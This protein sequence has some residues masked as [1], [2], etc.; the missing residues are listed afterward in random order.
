MNLK[1]YFYIILLTSSGLFAQKAYFIDGYHGGIWGHYPEGYTSYVVNQLKEHPDWK[2]N[3]EIEPETWDRVE[4]MDADSYHKLQE[5]FKDQSAKGRVEYVNP[6]Y[7]QGYLFNISGESIISQF[8]YGIKK[9][10][11]HFPTA[12]FTSYSSEEPC[13]TSALPQILTSFG[14]TNASLKNP[15]T[16][17]GG[18]TRAHG[19]E[20]VN[21]I[22]PDGTGITTVPR[23]AIEILK[24]GSAWETIGNANSPE[25]I[26]AAF[27]YGIKNP[28]GMTLQDAGWKL[29]PW[30]KK[31]QYKPSEYTTWRNYFE[32]VADK[33]NITDWNFSQEDVLVSLVWGSQVLQKL[34]QEVRASENKIIQAEKIAFLDLLEN[35][36]AYPENR[37]QMAWQPLLLSQHHDCWIVPYNISKG[38]SWAQKVEGWTNFTDA[39]S[40]SI[41]NRE[42]F[43]KANTGER[44][45]KVYNTLGKTRNELVSAKVPKGWKTSET[46]VFDREGRKLIMQIIPSKDG[47]EMLF[48]AEIPA[49]GYSVFQLKKEKTAAR[50]NGARAKKLADGTYI[51]ETD[52][53]K[54]IVDPAQGGTI[55]SLIAK[56]L[57]KREFVDLN[58][59]RSFNELRGNFYNKGGFKSST[60]SPAEVKI[61]ANGPQQVALSIQGQIAGNPFTQIIS[62][63]QGQKRIE[64]NVKIDWKGKQGIGEFE[65]TDYEATNLKKAFYNDKYKLLSLFP[66]NLTDQKVYKNAPF[67]VT[68]TGLEDTFFSR[69]DEIKNNIILNWVDVTDGNGQY[70]CALFTDHTTSYAHGKDFPLGLNV[71]YAGQGLWGRQ[72]TVEGSTEI[73]YALIPHKGNWQ[74]AELWQQNEL[75][76]EP[77]HAVSFSEKPSKMQSSLLNLN[78][79][80]WV[81][82]SAQVQDGNMLIR[83]FNAEGDAE[84]GSVNFSFDPGNVELVELNGKTRKKLSVDKSNGSYQVKLTMPQ[85]GF[86]TLKLSGNQN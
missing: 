75:I 31:N 61:I 81:L 57:G 27:D 7:A 41:M 36:V 47:G 69:W 24:P 85:F 70:G 65:E 25:Y 84:T 4:N 30:L 42:A 80:G 40:D 3:L 71:Q 17:W 77:L 46:A 58:S 15:N 14:Y 73:N 5:F 63:S 56:D 22:G 62:L 53:Y 2:A 50:N 78:K 29:G 12:I 33:K 45:L 21:W 76:K 83:I 18:Y 72:Y 1:K 79:S 34:A 37:F 23:Y 52:L 35:G 67:D 60:E 64:L 38:T 54:I 59:E 86:R 55:K 19:G 20:L 66:L 16:C 48:R 74:E 28:I 82:S 6:T 32:N 43:A 9:V 49:F 10:H 51:L 44:F 39:V 11:E 68:E 13:F 26:H 8:H